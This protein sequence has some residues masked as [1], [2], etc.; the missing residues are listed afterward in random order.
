M[1]AAGNNFAVLDGNADGSLSG[2]EVSGVPALAGTFETF[3]TNRD[4]NLSRSEWNSFQAQQAPATSAVPAVPAT[5]GVPASSMAERGAL[6]PSPAAGTGPGLVDPRFVEL[7]RNRDGQLG[8]DELSIEPAMSER[9]AE[10][11]L[12]GDGVLSQREYAALR[13]AVGGSSPVRR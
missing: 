4:G 9:L 12:N 1:A 11:D 10:F 7:D 6:Q 5:P 3:D 2:A 13:T 8:R